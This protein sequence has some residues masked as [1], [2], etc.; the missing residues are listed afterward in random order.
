[1][2]LEFQHRRAVTALLSLLDLV[3]CCGEADDK[4]GSRPRGAP[5]VKEGEGV[6]VDAI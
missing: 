2:P 3:E 5:S 6:T 1:M 4:H